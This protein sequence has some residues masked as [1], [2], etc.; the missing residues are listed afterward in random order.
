[1]AE[2]ERYQ[3]ARDAAQEY[4][5]RTVQAVMQPHTTAIFDHVSLQDGDRVLDVACGTGIVT[6]IAVTRFSNIASIVG[7]DL[8]L[9]M[10]EIARAHT[11]ATHIPVEWR[12]GDACMLP[13][14]DHSFDVVLCQQGMQYIPD[15]LVA[16][17]EMKRVLSP[18]ERLVFT[19]WSTTHRHG[20][21]LA[22]ALRRHVSDEAATKMLAA[23]AWS[24]ADII[25]KS[26]IDAGFDAIE[27]EI[28]ESQSRMS[29][30]ADS[31]RSYVESIAS[32]YLSAHEIEE[33]RIALAQDVSASL[34]AYRVG[35]E[36]IMPSYAHL[37]Q[38]RT[39]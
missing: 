31:V 24:D 8:N 22:D 13:F 12:E 19:V 38:A 37:V 3:L 17:R 14:P 9:N 39:P 4:E 7:V 23:S 2:V 25:R 27:M 30:S 36:Y 6:R 33:S 20:A 18:G 21:A 26:V 16:L 32:R 34:Q 5:Q 1:M 10:L 35:D 15:K 28:V 29:S 11:P